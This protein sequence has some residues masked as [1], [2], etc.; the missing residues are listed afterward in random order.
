MPVN[1]IKVGGQTKYRYGQTGKAYSSKAKAIKQGI[2]IRLSQKR[3]GKKV[4]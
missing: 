4:K 3:A 1:K 2:A